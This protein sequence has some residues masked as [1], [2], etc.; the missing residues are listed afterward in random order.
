[1]PVG[2]AAA[3]RPAIITPVDADEL[4]RRAEARYRTVVITGL[5]EAFLAGPWEFDRIAGRGGSTLGR[6]PDWMA[7]LALSVT[8]V[9]R[10]PPDGRPDQLYSL[11]SRFFREHGVDWPLPPPE[12]V[13][14]LLIPPV[15][16]PPRWGATG[17]AS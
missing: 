7:A 6:W 9:Y 1:M 17:I 3:R 4:R 11:I 12:P 15:V 5:V 8:T 14:R 10:T 16:S 13:P 2:A